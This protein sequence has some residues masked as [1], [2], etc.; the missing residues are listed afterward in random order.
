MREAN[1]S[2]WFFLAFLARARALTP[3]WSQWGRLLDSAPAL[4]LQLGIALQRKR[5]AS[6]W[7]SEWK[8]DAVFLSKEK[9]AKTGPCRELWRYIFGEQASSTWEPFLA[10]T[11]RAGFG[12]DVTS[13]GSN[14]THWIKLSILSLS[15]TILQSFTYK[16]DMQINILL[17]FSIL[18]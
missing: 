8:R 12:I 18:I 5:D 14:L 4:S 11:H 13:A 3:T 10:W 2:G 17:H 6:S 16:K 9:M 7:S 1:K 15:Y